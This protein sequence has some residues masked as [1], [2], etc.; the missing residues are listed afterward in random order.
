MT[1]KRKVVK[2]TI[3]GSQYVDKDTGEILGPETTTVTVVDKEL[4]IMHSE[5]YVILDSKALAYIQA[6]FNPMDMGRILQMADMTYGEYNVLYNKT[7]PHNRESLMEELQYSRN[8]FS[9]FLKR[10][11]MKSIIYYISGY[12]NGKRVKYFMLNPHLARK[13]KTI[14]KDCLRSFQPLTIN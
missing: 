3:D 5:E 6:H 10:L 11:E 9:N 2:H 12:N 14:H 13:R 1:L 7:V 4:M 8:K